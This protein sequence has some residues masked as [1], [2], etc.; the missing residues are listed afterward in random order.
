MKKGIS[1]TRLKKF[2]EA[3]SDFDKAIQL[4]PDQSYSYY[5]KGKFNNIIRKKY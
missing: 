4:L 3:I 1:L 5:Q 2:D